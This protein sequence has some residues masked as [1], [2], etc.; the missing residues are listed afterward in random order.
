M[1]LPRVRYEGAVY[2]V[3]SRGHNHGS[4]FLGEP[5]R[6]AFLELL[7]VVKREFGLRVYAWTLAANHFHLLV[8][9]PNANLSAAMKRLIQGHSRSFNA[10]HRRT[11][12]VF[13]NRYKCRLVEKDRY[14]LDLVRYIHQSPVKSGL[15]KRVADFPWS[16]HALYVAQRP[17]GLADWDGVLPVLSDDPAAAAARYLEAIEAPIPEKDWKVLD[18]KRNGILG[19]PRFRAAVRPR[20]SKA[21]APE[22]VA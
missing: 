8:E 12:H 6:L 17:G 1:R 14:L 3:Y 22:R 18:R 9:T 19:G 15:V 7:K 10:R 20:K 5:D 2:H 4:I 13:E 16:S 11:G 21:P